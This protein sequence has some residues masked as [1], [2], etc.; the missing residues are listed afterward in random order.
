MSGQRILFVED[1][2]PFRTFASRYLEQRG[3]Q[4]S[5]A[6]TGAAALDHEVDELDLVLLDLNLPDLHGLE[7]LRRLL[8][9]RPGLRVVVVTSLGD[10][11]SAVKA[12][13]AGASDYLTKPIELET[14]LEGVKEALAAER[15]P[16][17]AEPGP[18]SASGGGG[19]G[20]SELGLE[21]AHRSWL[22]VIERVRRVS[23][24]QLPTL[25][26]LGESGTGKSALA[27]AAHALGPRRQGP[28]V[29]LACPS[30]PEAL[31]ES[32][33]FGHEQGAF[34]GA[35]RRRRGQAELAD[36]GTLFLDEIGELPP[37]L[38]AKLLRFLEERRFRPVGGEQERE[39]DLHVVC[40]T[41]RDLAHD[42]ATGSF[43][44]DL[45][46]RLE[47][48]AIRLPA[49]R[50]R[51][52]DVLLL[53]EAFLA[54]F[55]AEM[56]REAPR[57]GEDAREAL[58]AHPFPG[59]VR[60]LRNLIQRSLA[61][62]DGEVLRAADLELRGVSAA[63]PDPAAP[64]PSRGG[65]ELEPFEVEPYLRALEAHYLQLALFGSKSQT[66]AA[67]LLGID[68]FALA[69]RC[70]RRGQLGGAEGAAEIRADAPTWAQRLVGELPSELPPEGIDLGDLLSSYELTLI[71]YVV[72]RL[73]GNRSQAAALLSMSRATLSRR[74][75]P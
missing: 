62:H 47:V 4:V 53:T 33:L 12:L 67:K 38:Q 55:A 19:A 29:E 70:A 24:S 40:A 60:E 37:A 43:R 20:L 22:E 7:I 11:G 42:V 46:Y 31:L 74:L 48:A 68:R 1:E 32:E 45:Y 39:V 27:R 41:N 6:G 63:L 54:R 18:A 30:I 58:L 75:A 15:A 64:G 34:T 9:R 35:T 2:A 49:L 51:G 13:K 21:G 72:Q 17:A 50:E 36:G 69:R 10:A 61:F 57:L 73:E 26:L 66:E 52:Q 23:A 8:A 14:L 65:E 25:L 16:A 71:R 56:G 5:Q 59:N 28:F 3:F 44:R